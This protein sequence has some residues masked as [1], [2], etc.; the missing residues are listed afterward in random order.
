M[1]SRIHIYLT[2][3]LISFLGS[4]PFG[5][6]NITAFNIA[7][8][9]SFSEAVY[10]SL[11]VV[12]IELIVVRIT[13]K[14][15][16]RINFEGG[17]IS[18]AL[19]VAAAVLLYL[20][21]SGFIS[22]GKI[23]ASGIQP[24]ILPLVKSAFVLGLVLSLSNPLHFPFWIGWNGVLK[25]KGKL[26]DEKGMY[27]SYLCGIGLGSLA[28][29]ILYILAGKY[30]IGGNNRFHFLITFI[31]SGLYL[32]FSGYL[33]VVFIRKYHKVRLQIKRRA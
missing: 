3:F 27:V 9:R 14:F 24:I 25:A 16:K 15:S 13:L 29:L 18:L 31:T 2:G 17:L 26:N 20:S 6:L 4:L 1:C 30:L 12:L 21:I 11:A 32:I 33:M 8:Y 19:P 28:A 5:T 22:A 7:A 10:Y 23:G